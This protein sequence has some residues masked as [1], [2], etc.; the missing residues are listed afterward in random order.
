MSTVR[1]IARI[2][3]LLSRIAALVIM[4]VALYAIAVVLLSLF[5]NSSAVPIQVSDNGTFEIFFP[6]TRTPFLLGDY[7]A[8]YLVSNLSVVTFYGLFLWLL[9]DVFL[10]FK[11]PKLF[12]VR[13]VNRL[14]RFY[15]TN[16]AMPFLFLVLLMAFG[17]EMIDLLR[18]T[19]LHIVIGVFAFFMA[20]IFKQGLLLQEEQDLIF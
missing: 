19:L 11:Q 6:F 8:S 17:H 13:G 5:T 15:I 7:T 18:I 4:V 14:S 1:F 16:L 10:A 3:F 12:T 9:S 20:A 2:L